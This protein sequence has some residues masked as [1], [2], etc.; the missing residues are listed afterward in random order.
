MDYFSFI[1]NIIIVIFGYPYD[2][3]W[4]KKGF[5]LKLPGRTTDAEDAFA[6]AKEL[7][8]KG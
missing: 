5:A 7:G 6:K 3:T 4:V 1:P 2:D 8:Y